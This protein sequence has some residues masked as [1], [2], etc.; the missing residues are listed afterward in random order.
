MKRIIVAGTG[1]GVGKT[2]VS[3]ILAMALKAD[4]WK[5]IECGKSDTHKVQKWIE[6]STHRPSY[7][8][9]APLSPHAAAQLEN[10]RIVQERIK[11][12]HVERALIIETVG[13]VFTP[14]AENLVSLDLFKQWDASWIVVSK[15]YLGSINQTLLTLEALKKAGVDILGIVFNGKP[16]P[17]SESAILKI[18]NVPFF[19]RVLPE[20][21]IRAKT[22]K[23]YAEQFS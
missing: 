11:I 2:V 21:F 7:R 14:L 23:K 22:I 10:I 12:P 8:F 6:T 20:F 5:P 15:H 1:T 3:A 19:A 9:K 13:G 18:S 17:A 16:N 4:Y